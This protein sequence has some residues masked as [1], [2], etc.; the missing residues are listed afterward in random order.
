[1][2]G[3]KPPNLPVKG[4]SRRIHPSEHK[5]KRV[6]RLLRHPPAINKNQRNLFAEI[7]FEELTPGCML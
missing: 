1:M 6:S 2:F 4:W 7:S 5:K 3:Y